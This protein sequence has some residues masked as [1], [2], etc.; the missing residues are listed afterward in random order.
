MGDALIHDN[1]KSSNLI[2]LN[3][4][5]PGYIQSESTRTIGTE[6]RGPQVRFQ[7]TQTIQYSACKF[8]KPDPN[9]R[10]SKFRSL[11]NY[12]VYDDPEQ[13]VS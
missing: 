2:F 3:R 4:I 7:L 6:G 13:V 12:I 9:K 10:V 11:R 1:Y 5:R 8:E